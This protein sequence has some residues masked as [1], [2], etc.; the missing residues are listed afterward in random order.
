MERTNARHLTPA[1]FPAG[2]EPVS[3]VVADCS[4]ISLRHILPAGIALLARSGKIV[5]LVKPQFEAGK[6]EADRGAGVITDPA[7]HRRVLEE[8]AAFAA[9]LGSVRWMGAVESPLR[10]PAGN[11]E[12]LALMTKH[13]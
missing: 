7:I 6:A 5:A 1:S 10:G 11:T 13:G 12:F 3:L 4:F 8:L 2:F 9:G